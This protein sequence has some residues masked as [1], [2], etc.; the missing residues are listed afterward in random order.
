MTAVFA[1]AAW[2]RLIQISPGRPRR[3]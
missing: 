3:R 1:L 2:W